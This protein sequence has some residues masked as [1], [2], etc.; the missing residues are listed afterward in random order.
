MLTSPAKGGARGLQGSDVSV[1]SAEFSAK[2]RKGQFPSSLSPVSGSAAQGP[3][4]P[5]LLWRAR[6]LGLPARFLSQI[7]TVT[8]TELQAG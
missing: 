2:F 3:S 8:R 6:S 5:G 1:T 4:W 7:G